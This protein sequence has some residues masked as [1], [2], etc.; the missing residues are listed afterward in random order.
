VPHTE[1]P[2]WVWLM[3]VWFEIGGCVQANKERVWFG[4]FGNK[5]WCGLGVWERCV[6][7]AL[8]GVVWE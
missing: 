5:Q 6:Y 3:G 2:G 4:S 1:G 8:Y 7:I